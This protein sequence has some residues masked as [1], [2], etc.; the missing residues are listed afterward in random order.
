MIMQVRRNQ[1][2]ARRIE[3]MGVIFGRAGSQPAEPLVGMQMSGCSFT[4]AYPAHCPP[5]DEFPGYSCEAC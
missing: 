5:G 1:Y 2:T 3:T 4:E